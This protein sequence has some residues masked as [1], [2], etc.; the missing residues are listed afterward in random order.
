M[1]TA[2][3]QRLQRVRRRCLGNLLLENLSWTLALAGLAGAALAAAE[4]AFAFGLLR[5]WALPA[6]AGAAAVLAGAVWY[7]RLP[8]LLG[9]AVLIDRDLALK[10]RMSTTLALSQSEDPFALAARSD[11]HLAAERIELKG[12]YPIRLSRGWLWTVLAWAVA[13]AVIL[14]LPP[15]DLLGKDRARSAQKEEER[16]LAQ[17]RQEVKEAVT[18]IDVKVQQLPDKSLSADLAKAAE[19][20]EA[21]K[22][23]DVKHEAIRKLDD[24]A[25]K[26]KKM[27][28]SPKMESVRDLKDMLKGLRPPANS[29]L[30]KLNQDIAKGDFA[31][32]AQR[33]RDVE[34]QLEDGN[35]PKEQKDALAKQ[36]AE[37]GKQL[38][39]MAGKNKELKDALGDAGLGKELADL[40]EKE[41]K[42]KLQKDA[43]DKGMS[44]E[45]IDELQKKAEA[46]RKAC[47]LAKKLGQA[48]K[49]CS[50]SGDQ[51]GTQLTPEEVAALL[52]ELG[53]L[54]GEMAG[55][56]A[57]GEALD[58][59][60]KA[61]A[62]LGQGQCP[63]GGLAL[64]G[65]GQG[66]GQMPGTG[67]KGPFGPGDAQGGKPGSGTGGPGVGMG[68]RGTDSTGNTATEKTR[69]EG[70]KKDGPIVASWLFKGPQITGDSKKQLQDV[71][72]ASRDA[73]AEAISDNEIP[74]K[75]KDPVTK[76]FGGLEEA[77]SRPA[78]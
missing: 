61:I 31:S 1:K 9:G 30:P 43:N 29:P 25:E 38:E 26:I 20:P 12:K 24:L 47:E 44:Q 63:G 17:A 71:I 52:D 16:L 4:R 39:E 14:F 67:G 42:D 78:P 49:Q 34:K 46:C 8:S 40:G 59:I 45:Q 18:K 60:E 56:G 51:P 41:F 64:G 70:P 27:D 54:E 77:T 32:A 62:R 11:A 3:E 37:L 72:Q 15:L 2:F 23:E 74:N 13:A 19:A 36:L 10:E 68:A 6:L 58:E 73:A 21:L 33:L 28:A 76:Y 35:V 50:G 5:P 75:Y 57:A 66:Q 53:E 48:M 55:L 65:Q 7:R 22:P 69:V